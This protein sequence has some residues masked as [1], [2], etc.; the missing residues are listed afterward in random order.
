[1]SLSRRSFLQGSLGFASVGLMAPGLLGIGRAAAAED[2]V[3]AAQTPLERLRRRLFL[4]EG[5]TQDRSAEILKLVAERDGAIES[6]LKAQITTAGSPSRGCLWGDR[7]ELT[8]AKYSGMWYMAM[9]PMLARGY[10]D[11]RSRYYKSPAIIEAIEA[12]LKYL[13]PVLRIDPAKR[14]GFYYWDIYNNQQAGLTLALCGDGLTA[15]GHK[16]LL[17][18]LE[19]VPGR[20]FTVSRAAG[21]IK[22][23]ESGSNMLDVMYGLLLRGI[24]LNDEEWVKNVAAQ[25][26]IAMGKAPG[27]E[28]IQSDWSYHFHGRGINLGYGMNDIDMRSRWFFLTQGTPWQ[29]GEET[30][31]EYLQLISEFFRFNFWQG[32]VSPYVVDRSIAMPGGIFGDYK[33]HD[34]FSLALLAGF[35]E[36]DRQMLAATA[37]QCLPKAPPD[38]YQATLHLRTDAEIEE[39]EAQ[40]TALRFYPESDYFIAR[41]AKWFA[42]IRMASLRT[43]AW[44]TQSRMHVKGS[45]S[46]EF[47]IALMTDG[48]E[49]DDSTIPTM[50]WNRLMGVTRCDAIEAP[51]MSYGQSTFVGGLAEDNSHGVAA[52]QYLLAPPDQETLTGNKSV[53][54][55]RDALVLLGNKIHCSSQGPVVTTLFHAPLQA[56]ADYLRNGRKLQ[57][58]KDGKW[59][60]RAGETL[61]LR[62][63]AIQ[64]LQPATLFVETRAGNYAGLNDPEY[65]PSKT[66]PLQ[67]IYRNRWC[68]LEVHHGVRPEN[69]VYGAVL[70]PAVGLEFVPPRLEIR[71]A[72]AHHRL[73]LADGRGAE[74]RFPADW[75]AKGGLSYSGA[76]PFKWGS[77]SQWKPGADADHFELSILSPR[78]YAP[79]ESSATE[80]FLPDGF[81]VE[82]VTLMSMAGGRYPDYLLSVGADGKVKTMTVLKKK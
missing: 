60:L 53:F 34:V 40:Y 4:L 7:G 32:R 9:H 55:T 65:G 81:V 31:Q 64:L 2:A 80:L 23:L 30:Q 41:Q 6:A 47:S 62:N 29:I 63:V 76:E 57:V 37:R 51:P 20:V 19:T 15:D 42:A 24:G 22:P 5:I 56:D 67:K 78:R 54:A 39:A 48:S 1:M 46:G 16:I 21:V 3:V 8:L 52:M 14:N 50:K 58:G 26:P 74:A 25:L 12:S 79:V 43:K 33:M 72:D 38:L 69:G 66:E 13:D 71:Q 36:K 49:F 17:D 68:Y 45:S 73:D 75:R 11:A 70:W 10:A 61:F 35:S 18:F 77:I 27:G 44:D 28:G 59:Q 82:N